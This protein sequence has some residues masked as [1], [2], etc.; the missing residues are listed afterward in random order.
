MFQRIQK[1]VQRASLL[2]S[3]GSLKTVADKQIYNISKAVSA[4]GQHIYASIEN[5]K[6]KW[7]KNS[8]TIW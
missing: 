4:K 8:F 1:Q 6:C 2:D 5:L 7:P 3:V